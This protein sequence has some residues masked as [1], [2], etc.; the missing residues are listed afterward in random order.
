[1]AADFV[2]VPRVPTREMLRVIRDEEFNSDWPAGKQMQAE[3]GH[4]VV[5][6]EC[7]M[8]VAAGQYV[9]LLAAAQAPTVSQG[10][11]AR[12]IAAAPELLAAL[13]AVRAELHDDAETGATR[14]YGDVSLID[15]AIAKATQP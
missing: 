5:P 8:E 12:L 4:L 1:M 10:D 14:F 6:F 2:L 15:A 9:R 11:D 7:G 3:H 13:I